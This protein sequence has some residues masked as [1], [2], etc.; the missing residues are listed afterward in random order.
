MILP[1]SQL[2]EAYDK[3]LKIKEKSMKEREEKMSTI[4]K[5]GLERECTESEG[6]RDGFRFRHWKV[7][8][9]YLVLY[10]IIAVNLSYFFGLWLRFDLRYSHIPAEYL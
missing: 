10:D 7:I 9:M 6:K 8:A 3:F 1:D 5:N 4:K 2:K